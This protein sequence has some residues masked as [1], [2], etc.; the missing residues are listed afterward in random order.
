MD[1]LNRVY[2][3]NLDNLCNGKVL[4]LNL[5]VSRTEFDLSLKLSTSSSNCR[6]ALPFQLQ[7]VLSSHLPL[8][9]LT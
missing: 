9:F 5:G 1:F 4:L 2:E 3:P 8:V 7:N 6:G